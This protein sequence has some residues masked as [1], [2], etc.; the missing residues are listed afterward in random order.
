[1]ANTIDMIL[2]PDEVAYDATSRVPRDSII[3]E[4]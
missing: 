1:M 3:I 2:E 4:H